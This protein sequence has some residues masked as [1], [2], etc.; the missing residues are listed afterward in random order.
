MI[1][2]LQNLLIDMAHVIKVKFT[3]YQIEITYDNKDVDYISL[4][5][6]LNA[7][8]KTVLEFKDCHNIDKNL[9]NQYSGTSPEVLKRLQSDDLINLYDKDDLCA[10]LYQN[11]H[12]IRYYNHQLSEAMR[13][14]KKTPHKIIQHNPKNI[15][16]L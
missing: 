8:Y 1:I 3:E 5:K 15:I 7:P 4:A 14:S 10:Y 16:P 6:L 13:V 11:N 9:V 2:Q 12:I